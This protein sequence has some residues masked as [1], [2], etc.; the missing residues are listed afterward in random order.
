MSGGTGKTV[1]YKIVPA[2]SITKKVY[3]M[4][5]KKVVAALVPRSLKTW[6]Y[7][8]TIKRQLLKHLLEDY[9]WSKSMEQDKCIDRDGHPVPW[10]SYP[11]IDFLSQLDL[12]GKDVFEY[13]C[14]Y[15]TLFWGARTRSVLSVENH[16][17]WIQ[18]I[19][20]QLPANCKII[21]ALLEV[22]DYAGKINQYQQFD[23]IIIDGFIN[24]RPLCAENALKHLKPGGII[25]LDN[26][27]RCLKSAE[28]LRKG[29]LI[30]ADFTGFAPLSGDAQSTTIFFSRDY[31]F[32]PLRGYQP[33]K[34]VAQPNQPYPHG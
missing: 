9:G 4:K 18:K 5:I 34:S 23:I 21:H 24:S 2:L 11:A 29:G 15:S 8:L 28:I 22:E 17:K 19:E 3:Y 10:F 13:G 32:E 26:S 20:P 16:A 30:Q 25:V 7:K 6:K 31:D 12:S 1:K 27:D 14:G 33:H